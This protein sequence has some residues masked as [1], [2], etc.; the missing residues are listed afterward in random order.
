ML[1][2][3]YSTLLA[4]AGIAT[5]SSLEPTA[6]QS[7]CTT[8]ITVLDPGFTGDYQPTGTIT[9]YNQTV[10]I[11]KPTDCHGCNHVTTTVEP[12]P[13][14]GGIGP[15]IQKVIYVHATTPTTITSPVCATSTPSSTSAP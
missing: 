12:A 11:G 8:T 5:A 15:Q 3:L 9:I 14:W 7:E 10:T 1:S 2:L 13:W 4:F 6:T